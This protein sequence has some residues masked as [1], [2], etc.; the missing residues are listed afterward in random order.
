MTGR[1][2]ANAD[3]YLVCWQCDTCE[4]HMSGFLKIGESAE[5]TCPSGRIKGNPR[6][7]K[8]K[9]KGEIVPYSCKGKMVVLV[10]DRPEETKP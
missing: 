6:W 4:M 5:R 7:L 1:V 3:G 8:M 2:N 9:R 10:D